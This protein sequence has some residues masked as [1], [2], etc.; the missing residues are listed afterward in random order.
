M[1]LFFDIEM[2]VLDIESFHSIC[3]RV[4]KSVLTLQ[5]ANIEGERVLTD[6]QIVM[7][8]KAYK[9]TICLDI[10]N[11]ECCA[12]FFQ[13]LLFITEFLE[14]NIHI[15]VHFTL[16]LGDVKRNYHFILL[17]KI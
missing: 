10:T 1:H 11:E 15:I 16:P 17:Q 12:G 13:L 5:L 8:V 4:F 7:I 6:N 9:N 2:K 3:R 14:S